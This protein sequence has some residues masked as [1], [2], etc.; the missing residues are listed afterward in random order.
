VNT[1]VIMF[2]SIGCQ[3]ANTPYAK[4]SFPWEHF[5]YFCDYLVKNHY[6]TA[7]LSEWLSSQIKERKDKNIYL[8]FDDGFLD[9]WV[10]AFPILQKYQIKSTIFINPEFI[11]LGKAKRQTCLG[12]DTDDLRKKAIGYLNWVELKEMQA[13]GLV[14][15]QSH[16]MSH[17]WYPISNKVINIQQ[18]SNSQDYPWTI[19]NNS[20]N[21]KPHY[22]EQ[23]TSNSMQNYPIFENGRSL[24]IRRYFLSE[25]QIIE[26]QN[27]IA[28]LL[29][30]RLSRQEVIERVNIIVFNKRIFGRLETDQ[31][32]FERY[33]YEL[34]RSKQILETGLNKSI[35]FLCWPGGAY[36]DLSVRISREVG[37]LASTLT[38]RGDNNPLH[39]SD[40][41]RIPRIGVSS[42]W[43]ERDGVRF[44]QKQIPV[45]IL[46]REISGRRSFMSYRLSLVK[47]YKQLRRK[48]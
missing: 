9:N 10:Y 27:N 32:L 37:Y 36:N 5:E 28:D 17:T 41:R 13:S 25:E 2:H 33:Y 23:I 30:K 6:K 18:E 40:Y 38:S 4:L 48:K 47:K 24:G 44:Y 43:Y 31:E 29:T 22:L 16:S 19:W 42:Y 8:T 45:Y 7:F 15:I 46:N 34:A 11:Q 39:F 1:Q 35:D 12:K 20:P 21:T 14:D 26:I 3:H